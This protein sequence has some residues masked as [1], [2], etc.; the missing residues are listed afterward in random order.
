MISGIRAIRRA[1]LAA[2]SL[3]AACQIDERDVRV[4]TVQ[5]N[6]DERADAGA[7]LNEGPGTGCEG[8]NC[9]CLSGQTST[10]SLVF[11]SAGVC[12]SRLLT[13]GEGGIW[14]DVSAC[15]GTSPEVCDTS[16][17]DEDCDG[18]VDEICQCASGETSSCGQ[19]HSALGLCAARELVCTP[20][21]LWPNAASC[22][23]DG[24]EI[25]DARAL[26]ENC[27]GR[28]NEI[29]NCA[30]EATST[31]GAIHGAVGVCAARTLICGTAGQWPGE[32]ACTAEQ[33]ELCDGQALDEDCDG[34]V[35]ESCECD[36]GQVSSC[37]AIHGALGEC[38]SRPLSCT[39]A[40]LWTVATACAATRAEACLQDGVDEDCDGLLD[41]GCECLEGST[42]TCGVVH[43]SLGLCSG[44]VIRCGADGRW[45]AQSA[46]TPS[47]PELCGANAEDEDC[48]G[49]VNESP[50][51]EEFVSVRV[52]SAHSCALTAS[53]SLYCWGANDAGQLGDG[54]N[55]D[56]SLPTRVLGLTGVVDFSVGGR[57][58]CASSGSGAVQCWGDNANLQFADA[59]VGSRNAPGPAIPSSLPVQ[60]SSR[61]A[62]TCA[63]AGDGS[64]SCWGFYYP[65]AE[66]AGSPTRITGLSG[67][68]S[69]SVAG[70]ARCAL[71][72]D[73]SVSCWGFGGSGILGDGR[74]VDSTRVPVAVSG[75]SNA[76]SLA[77]D[78]WEHMCSV[79]QGGRVQCWGSNRSGQL[80]DGS[81][82]N[83]LVPVFVQQLTG[84]A[85]VCNGTEHTCALLGDG[86]VRCWGFLF[87]GFP[88]RVSNAPV[89][90]PLQIPGLDDI[91]QMACG[92]QHS[93]ATRGDGSVWCWGNN[94]LGQL[95]TGS[96]GNPGSV[97]VQVLTP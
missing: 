75:I 59:A 61:A 45:P 49:L 55:I 8:D 76:A 9:R 19:L 41:E 73:G 81:T 77:P 52:G 33:L 95:G 96:Q 69:V 54:T 18:E 86:T 28:V 85:T 88:G 27:D 91:A 83:R 44:R 70:G 40:G 15:A 26:D 30:P 80:G 6:V 50:P 87:Q 94:Q 72:T 78:A 37:G 36:F 11:G 38:A 67:V 32:E 43:G 4:V 53:R 23:P 64:V 1:L 29:C 3:S 31:C 22:A 90:A 24:P 17:L 21:G 39:P 5:S 12:G 66:M 82:T 10:C 60:M 93:C 48:D 34:A 47:G 57:H 63:V 2:L 14:P 20:E 56:R 71:A 65:L 62:E 35:D 25:C 42:A 89:L 13:C 68:R 84:A 46:C 7:Q 97:A 58:T 51:C 74:G 79:L 16:Q 92:G